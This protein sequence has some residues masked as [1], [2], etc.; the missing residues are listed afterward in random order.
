MASTNHFAESS[1]FF[2]K[3]AASF[4][5]LSDE[6]AASISMSAYFLFTFSSGT[7]KRGIESFSSPSRY[8]R[9]KSGTICWA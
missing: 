1:F 2:T 7:E 5:S 9:R 3:A 6:F 4:F 8:S